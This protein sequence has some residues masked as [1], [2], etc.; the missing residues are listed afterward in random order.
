MNYLKAKILIRSYFFRS[1]RFI[2]HFYHKCTIPLNLI[3]WNF[4]PNCNNLWIQLFFYPNLALINAHTFFKG[5]KYGEYDGQSITVISLSL[6]N[7]NASKDQWYLQLSICST[8]WSLFE[9][10]LN[11]S[12]LLFN[13]TIYFSILRFSSNI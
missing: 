13:I 8:T 6:Y 11:S 4:L 9:I 5:F 1:Y 12:K 3:I 7:C 10:S 2:L